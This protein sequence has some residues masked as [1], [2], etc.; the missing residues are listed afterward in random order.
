MTQVTHIID[1][2]LSVAHPEIIKRHPGMIN[3]PF[4]IDHEQIMKTKL[5]K[6]E[7]YPNYNHDNKLGVWDS[8]FQLPIL[9]KI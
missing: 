6:Q 5:L 9:K 2:H 1:T 7:I 8:P 3:D 4:L